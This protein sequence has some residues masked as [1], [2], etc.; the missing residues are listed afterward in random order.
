VS[1]RDCWEPAAAGAARQPRGDELVERVASSISRNGPNSQA[2]REAAKAP[3]DRDAFLRHLAGVAI[4]AADRQVLGIW[5]DARSAD[6]L[7][8]RLTRYGEDVAIVLARKACT[9]WPRLPRDVVVAGF[10]SV[11]DAGLAE[12]ARRG[13]FVGGAS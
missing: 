13:V 12:L 3:D 11:F 5:P 10:A 4:E 1:C 2:S 7:A 9:R 8:T 6:E